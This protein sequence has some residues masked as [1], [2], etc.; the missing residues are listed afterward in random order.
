MEARRSRD[1]GVFVQSC[2]RVNWAMREMYV[3]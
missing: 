1:G 3:H 2:S